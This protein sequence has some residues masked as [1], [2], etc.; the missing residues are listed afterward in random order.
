MC[1]H[2]WPLATSLFPACGPWLP[3]CFMQGGTYGPW[4]PAC[5]LQAG[6]NRGEPVGVCCCCGLQVFVFSPRLKAG[7]NIFYL[8]VLLDI[9]HYKVLLDIDKVHTHRDSV[10]LPASCCF[11][12]IFHFVL[13]PFSCLTAEAGPQF[14]VG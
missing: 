8:K 11:N 4:L 3:A 7:T 6:S 13:I 2:L 9:Q 14:S 5:F 12:Y 1:I 10:S